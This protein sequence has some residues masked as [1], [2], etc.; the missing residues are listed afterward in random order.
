MAT[1]VPEVV[2]ERHATDHD[3]PT[4]EEIPRRDAT[5]LALHRRWRCRR[6]DRPAKDGGANAG[7]DLDELLGPS[8]A[9]SEN[10]TRC[11]PAE[12]GTPRLALARSTASPSR[13]GTTPSSQHCSESTPP[14]AERQRD[15]ERPMLPFLQ[16]NDL[17]HGQRRRA[18]RGNDVRSRRHPHRRRQRRVADHRAVERDE[19]AGRIGADRQLGERG[20]EQR[21]LRFDL[22]ATWRGDVV[23]AVFEVLRQGVDGFERPP[24]RYLGLADVVEHREMRARGVGGVEFLERAAI[25]AVIGEVDA[26]LVVRPRGPPRLFISSSLRR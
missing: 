5:L 26:M 1:G 23:F 20:L 2:T 16:R 15:D 19:R 24:E 8:P 25:I 9:R 18:S 13:T 22:L 12:T 11:L 14:S 6:R 3:A 4:D 17:S 7:R 21:D 10:A